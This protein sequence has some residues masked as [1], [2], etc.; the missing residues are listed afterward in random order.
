MKSL[1][2]PILTLVLASAPAFAQNVFYPTHFTQKS[3]A[4][5]M[6][7]ASHAAAGTGLQYYGGP[8]ISNPKVFVVLWGPNVDAPTAAGM[9]DFFTALTKSDMMDWMDQYNTTGKSL[10][11]R[12]G[13]NQHI[14]KGSFAGVVTITPKVTSGTID[15]KDIQAELQRQIDAGTLAKP[16]DNTLYMTYFPAGMTISIEGMQSCSQFCAYHGFNGSPQSAHFYY[17]VMPD[18]GGACAFGCG[19][20]EHMDNVTAISTHEFCEAVSDPYPTPG[21]TPAYPQA[22]NDNGGQEIGDLCAG[23]NN[24]MTTAGGKTYA[25]QAEYDNASQSCSTRTWTAQ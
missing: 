7:Q 20:N 23:N 12:D 16:D 18:L 22:W 21:S 4:L 11:G 5:A 9:G 13:T 24:S 8:V 1:F 17:G 15:D 19:F 14:G 2:A 3:H 10:D 25:V 6:Y